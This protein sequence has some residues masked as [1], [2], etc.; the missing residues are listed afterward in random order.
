MSPQQSY[1]KRPSARGLPSKQAA[2]LNDAMGRDGVDR[3]ATRRHS[4]GGVCG[5][6]LR[7]F[8]S[9]RSMI[10]VVNGDTLPVSQTLDPITL[11]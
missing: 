6:L 3:I 7:I 11:S 5:C 10:T 4:D 2:L 9:G 1:E 8:N